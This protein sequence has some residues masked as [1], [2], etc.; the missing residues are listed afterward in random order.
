MTVGKV[1][2][3]KVVPLPCRAGDLR[4]TCLV[5]SSSSC[6]SLVRH[7]N[8]QLSSPTLATKLIASP[9]TRNSRYLTSSNLDLDPMGLRSS[10]AHST[11]FS[12]GRD[13]DAARDLPDLSGKVRM[14]FVDPDST[15]G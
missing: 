10:I 11:G 5:P 3:E 1:R 2:F 13:W 7:Q 8:S 9:R 15:G 6:P 4:Q 12:N 14:L